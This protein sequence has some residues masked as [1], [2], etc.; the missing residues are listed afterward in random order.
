MMA[1]IISLFLSIVLAIF[2]FLNVISPHKS[3]ISS[4]K[5]VT[6]DDSGSDIILLDED[7]AEV[8]ESIFYD[9]AEDS[10]VSENPL[11][12]A[13]DSRDYGI[14]TDAKAQGHTGCCWAFAAVS[15]AET[16][17]IK[18]NLA[19]ADINYSEAHLVWFGLRSLSDNRSDPTYGDGI[20]S[21]YPYS[22]GGNWLRSVFAFARWS[23]PQLEDNAPFYGFPQLMGN[24]DEKERYS[25]YAHLQNSRYI[26]SDDRD[27]IK[28]AIIDHGSIT[29]SYYHNN[30]FLQSDSENGSRYYQKSTTSSNHTAVIIGWDDNYSK[31]NF[32]KDPD[33]DGAWLVK[34]SW[35]ADWGDN[36]FFWLSYC[37][38]SL[39]Y[40]VSFDMESA[41]N[42]ENNNQ[43][44]GF[45]YKGW[46]YL[47]GYT[48]MSAANIFN[49]KKCDESVRAVSFHTVQQN[50]N[51]TV[52]IYTDLESGG[53]PTD[54]TLSARETGFLKYRGYYTI[55]LSAPVTVAK[56]SSYAAVITF[57]VPEGSNACIPIEYPDGFDGAHVRSYHGEEGVSYITSNR[58]F[59]LWEDTAAE[60]LNNVCIKTFSDN[61]GL[62]LKETSDLK[63]RDNYFGAFE[64]GT[65]ISPLVSEFKNRNVFYQ[66][67][68]IVLKDDEGNITDTFYPAFYGDLDG[69]GDCDNDDLKIEF[70]ISIGEIQPNAMQKLS[71]NLTGGRRITPD[72]YFELYGRLKQVQ[73]NE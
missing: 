68:C 12:S 62:R 2:P 71:G 19:P 1:S 47:T 8:D 33:S 21:E 34:N 53:S 57:D 44:D 64:I 14:I 56:G 6:V 24:Y 23:G 9:E 17:M 63:S 38:A 66:D 25:S 15:A 43:Y 42:Y 48:E 55:P 26:P 30:M 11:P 10:D 20:F 39:N 37:D 59:D 22:D 32:S 18:K 65:D 69:D 5:T 73:K 54:G 40:F 72:D 27:G 45:G 31:D 60:G 28:Q 29:V 50:V 35:G 13:Y 52:E 16:S 41:D 49:V 36:G 70:D 61:L 3:I 67:G 4:M 46:G 58:D 7:G 51:Y